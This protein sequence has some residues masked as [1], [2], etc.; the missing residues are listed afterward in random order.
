MLRFSFQENTKKLLNRRKLRKAMVETMGDYS[1]SEVEKKWRLYWEKKGTYKFHVK[2]KGKVYAIDTPPPTVS[3]KMHIGHAFSYS[4]QDFVAR[5]HRMKGENVFYPFGTDDNGLPTEKLVEKLKNVKST[6]MSRPDIVSLCEKTIVEI[7][8]D[9]VNDWKIIGMSCDFSEAYS[10]I[11]K[12]CIKTSQK[13]FIDLYNKHL[14]YQQTAPSMWCVHCQTAI[15]QAE[16]EDKE[17]DS[18]FNEVAFIL[19]N[20]EKIVIATTRP[21]LLAACVCVYVHP[22]DKRYTKL[23][24]KNITVPLFKHKVLIFADPSASQEK[25]TGI[26]MVCSYGDKYD[27]E[28]INKRKLTPRVIFTPDGKLNSLAGKYE[29]LGIKDARK[30]ILQDLEKEKLLI[31]K[32]N[33]K[34]T[35]NVH[36]RCG[37]EIE[38]LSSTQWFVKILDNKHKFI[39]AGRKIHWYPEFMRT[40]YEHWVEGLGWDWCISRQRHFGVPFPV[41]SCTTCKTLFIA[42]EKDLPVD[43]LIDKPKKKCSCGSSSF[44][45]E[46][47][48]M[49]TWA[50]SSVTP[51]IILNWANDKGYDTSMDMVPCSLRPQAHDIIRNWTFYTIVKS[52][53]HTNQIPWKDIVISGHVLDPKG[54]AM[55]KS[56]GNTIEPSVVLAKYP[57]DALRF[58]AAGSKLGDDLRYLEKDL[59]TGQK[60]VTK[61]WNAAKFTFPHLEDYTSKPKKLEAFDRWILSKLQKLIKDCSENFDIYEYSRVKAD[62]EK[63]FWITFCDLYLEVVKDRLYKP[64]ERGKVERQSGQYAISETF[65]TILKLFA[66]IMPYVTEEIYH[67][68]YAKKEKKDSIHL[69]SWPVF[70]ASLLDAKAEEIGDQLVEI[71]SEV[72]K[73][74]SMKSLSLKEPVKILTL[75]LEEKDVVGFLDDI[76]AVTKAEK[77]IFGK[78]LEIQ[79]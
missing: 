46:N 18:T 34:H 75:P 30:D 6:K 16:L 4:Q 8:P 14:V 74:K 20:G 3:G 44:Q 59:L 32:K 77:I 29:G 9:F 10:T 19:E 13:S 53:Y 47:D 1:A 68:H 7:K 22:E 17:L 5:Y 38:F 24:G 71:I 62:T 50:T 11:D 64:E 60:T 35:V 67:A 54:E 76:K 79:L 39:D 40:R 25:G 70:S 12:H 31:S 52:M 28:A 15:A 55:H 49:D 26:L 36:E 27:V 72:R 2:N 48:V 51:E 41:W 56:K 23:I 65:G 45:G 37:T 42:D 78:T 73:A 58:W 69:S 21:E 33:I 57:A 63:F 43:P 66:P 61:L